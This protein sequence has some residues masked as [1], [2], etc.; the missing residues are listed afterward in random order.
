MLP[1]HDSKWYSVKLC[2][3]AAAARGLF[4]LALVQQ[5]IK[6]KKFLESVASFPY[7][8]MKS[9]IMAKVSENRAVFTHSSIQHSALLKR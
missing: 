4:L 6:F 7:S 2:C 3:S 1:C 5:A 8:V 9:E